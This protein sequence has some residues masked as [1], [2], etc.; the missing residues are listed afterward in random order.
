MI[1]EILVFILGMAIL[2]GG[3]DILIKGS[4]KLARSIGI[5]PLIIG[6]TLVAFGTSFPEL[7]VSLLAAFQHNPDI[8]IGNV[9]GSNIVNIGLIIGLAALVFPLQVA[10]TTLLLES[11]FMIFS[12]FLLL[13]FGYF[14]FGAG[15]SRLEGIILLFFFF[16][17]ISYIFYMANKERKSSKLYKEYKAEYSEGKK[18]WKPFLMIIFGLAGVIGGAKFMVDSAIK[19]ASALGI[20]EG[21]IALTVIAV[22]TSL[23]ELVT[24]VVAA[25]KKEP[26][27]AIG[28]IIGSNIFNILLI[29]GF[30]A[31]IFPLQV[32]SSMMIDMLIMIIF[33]IAFLVFSFTKRA[34]TKWE[35]FVLFAG[36]LA[37]IAFLIS[38]NIGI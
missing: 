2:L 5:S 34:I 7:S 3:A 23:P 9:I 10:A 1:L 26:D 15:I 18:L 31:S 8:S 28:N 29:V 25:Y 6:L 33:S 4:A 14:S 32:S 11:P 13:L 36:Y 35:G 16:I 37:Y 22:G 19:I 38:R 17:F 21:I 27:I 12:S 24:S 30:S 20:S